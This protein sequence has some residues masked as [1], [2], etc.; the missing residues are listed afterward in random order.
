MRVLRQ[1]RGL[2]LALCFTVGAPAV[3]AAPPKAGG[4]SM[5]TAYWTC[6]ANGPPGARPTIYFSQVGAVRQPKFGG[7]AGV[8]TIPEKWRD[9]LQ[10]SAISFDSRIIRPGCI[11]VS[12]EGLSEAQAK[13]SEHISAMA[14]YHNVERL[15]YTP[16][17]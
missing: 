8:R 15:T 5:V 14:K 17:P 11:V 7:F 12:Y 13:Q 6:Q 2:T 4:P 16:K 9:F 3:G 1:L 10:Q